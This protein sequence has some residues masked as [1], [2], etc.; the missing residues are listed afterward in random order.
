[1]S[2]LPPTTTRGTISLFTSMRV[3]A[4]LF[5]MANVFFQ[6]H[7]GPTPAIVRLYSEKVVGHND[8][9]RLPAYLW[10]ATTMATPPRLG[11]TTPSTNRSSFSNSI[12]NDNNDAALLA[13]K[14]TAILSNAS[15]NDSSTTVPLHLCTR[16][17]IQNGAWHRL[18]LDKPPYIPPNNRHLMCGSVARYHQNRFD[19]WEWRPHDGDTSC[20]F[21]KWDRNLFC[22][23]AHGDSMVVVGDSLSEEAVYA[24]SELLHTRISTDESLKHP[25][26]NLTHACGDSSHQFAIHFRRDDFLRPQKVAWEL[27]DKLPLIA[28][29]NRGAHFVNDTHLIKDIKETIEYVREWQSKCDDLNKHCLLIWRTT[30]PGHPNCQNYKQLPDNVTISQMEDLIQ[31]NP[32]SRAYNWHEFQ[33]QNLLIEQA[34]KESSVRY[35]IMDAYYINIVRPDDHRYSNNDCLHTCLGSKLDVY[36]QIILHYLR[37]LRQSAQ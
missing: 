27:L 33:R 32:V 10:N 22:Q 2:N 1:M 14:T 4:V 28:V 29:L 5:V 35:Q 17:Q 12:N 20:E 13:T 16:E 18:T 24:M 36:A 30:V 26:Y 25:I 6:I 11:Y 9:N 7:R 21:M 31:N 8:N 34:L 19:T 15:N 37:Q 23:L 3:T